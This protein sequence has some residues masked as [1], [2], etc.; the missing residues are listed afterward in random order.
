[1]PS[2]NSAWS[3]R[4]TFA[5][6]CV[7]TLGVVYGD[8]GTSPLYT[9]SEIFFGPNKIAYT[10][11]NAVGATSLV[12]WIL[13]LSVTLK[14][15]LLVL[16]ANH[17]GQG[18]T[19]ALLALIRGGIGSSARRQRRPA[20]PLLGGLGLALVL[21]AGLL[22]GEGIITPAI[23]VLSAVEGLKVATNTF[24]PFVVPATAL[25][26]VAL[27]TIQGRGTAR[28]G[29]IFGPVLALWFLV[30]ATLG[31]VNIVRQ[32]GILVALDPLNAIRFLATSGL[33]GSVAVLGSVLLAVTGCEALFADLG[34]FGPRPIRAMWF[35]LVY[36]ALLLNY[37][38]QGAY[39]YGGGPVEGGHL[40]YALVP[41]WGLLP[42]V[43]LATFATVIASQ[44]L[45][46]GAF[47]LTRQAIALGLFPRLQVVH[48]SGIHEGQIYVPVINR[49]LLVSC[50]FIVLGFGSSSRLAAAY[51]FAVSG[52][53]LVTSIAMT[54][55]AVRV[56]GWRWYLAAPLFGFFGTIEAI[57]FCSSSLKIVHGAWL[58][59]AI[60]LLVFTVMTTWQWGR[61]RVA[62]VYTKLTPHCET[63]RRIVELKKKPSI[64]QLPRSVV[65]MS[66]KPVLDRQDRIPPALHLFW[67]RLGALPKHIVL[68]TVRQLPVP[69]AHTGETQ[70]NEAVTFL[71]DP[72]YGSVVSLVST[73]GYMETPD[74]RRSLEEAKD[75]RTIKVPGDPRR[76]LVLVGQEN[77]TET[78]VSLLVR[79]R[80]SFFRTMLRNS[81]PAHLYFGLG[82]DSLVTSETVHLG[83]AA[84]DD[85]EP[86]SLPET[87]ESAV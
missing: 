63:V 80:L 71:S 25:I 57:F 72:V 87:P 73:Y 60:G 52:V 36:P 20:A 44:A 27:F 10:P 28:V 33:P 24:E 13:T 8:I 26:L 67:T 56:W 82:T 42:M 1:M 64:P 11:G 31:I 40:F 66:S 15:I 17:E 2:S 59:L 19:F 29:V 21:A 86:V 81:V 79:L 41:R 85:D 78:K 51:G 7:A 14:Y 53:M 5:A 48:T 75:L 23:S 76:W 68:L 12:L 77:V 16:R 74:V 30:I 9:V 45:I 22:Y 38:G 46:S 65:V 58:P 47:S 43:G 55:I 32:P 83:A 61:E 4:R 18:G 34:H 35:A 37:L 50:V 69:Y 3:E 6:L 70:R 54:V 49:A 62:G 84:F 39:V